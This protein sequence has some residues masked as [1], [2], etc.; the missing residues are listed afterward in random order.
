MNPGFREYTSTD[1]EP[2]DQVQTRHNRMLQGDGTLERSAD[3][4]VTVVVQLAIGSGLWHDQK[5]N[6]S[7][8]RVMVDVRLARSV[9]HVY[10]RKESKGSWGTSRPFSVPL[11]KF[12]SGSALQV[13]VTRKSKRET[14]DRSKNAASDPNRK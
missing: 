10:V 8:E 12:I 14:N 9:F 4:E 1:R 6:L 7:F 3:D 5:L 2:T 13:W 11:Q